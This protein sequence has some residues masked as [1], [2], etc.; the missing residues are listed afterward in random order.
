MAWSQ[1]EAIKNI[2]LGCKA[3]GWHVLVPNVDGDNDVGGLVIGTQEFCEENWV[4]K[5]WEV[6]DT[7][8]EVEQ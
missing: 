5:E 2:L 3:L 8:K 6:W 4:S 1:E 7:T